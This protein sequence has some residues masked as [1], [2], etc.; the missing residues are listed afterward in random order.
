MAPLR[1]GIAVQGVADTLCATI[2]LRLVTASTPNLITL[3]RLVIRRPQM[4]L[5]TGMLP[6]KPKTESP[7]AGQVVSGRAANRASLIAH[8]PTTTKLRRIAIPSTTTKPRQRSTTPAYAGLQTRLI[9][10]PPQDA[11]GVVVPLRSIADVRTQVATTCV[12]VAMEVPPDPILLTIRTFV[13][14][15]L[16]SKAAR[17]IPTVV[18][19]KPSILGP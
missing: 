15:R 1:L 17:T 12:Q 4:N 11:T 19:P 13:A 3:V 10:Q 2:P 5:G 18:R 14:D 7:T 8:V 9:L 16:R 6:S